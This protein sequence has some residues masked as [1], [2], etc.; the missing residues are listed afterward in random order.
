MEDVTK[1]SD[2]ELAEYLESYKIILSSLMWDWEFD[3]AEY[4]HCME[5][6][7]QLQQETENR[8][9]RKIEWNPRH[10]ML[11]FSRDSL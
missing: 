8:Q 6:I 9:S 7:R 3:A 2:A 10:Y 1:F 5:A 4:R 11:L